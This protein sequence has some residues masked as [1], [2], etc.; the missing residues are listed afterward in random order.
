VTWPWP[1]TG[2]GVHRQAAGA[3]SAAL[4]TGARIGELVN[5]RWDDVTDQELAFW[6]TKN[7][8]TSGFP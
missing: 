5:L 2:G 6:N 1:P 3:R 4:I 7:G 8:K